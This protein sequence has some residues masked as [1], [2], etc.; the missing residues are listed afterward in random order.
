MRSICSLLVI[1]IILGINLITYATRRLVG[2][3]Q[4]AAED[5]A[6]NN[7]SVPIGE[8]KEERVSIVLWGHFVE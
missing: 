1:K 6:T 4:R 5:D 8:T 3:D 7:S 2:K